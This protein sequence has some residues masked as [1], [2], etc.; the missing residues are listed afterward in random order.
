M[1]CG[2]CKE[3]NLSMSELLALVDEL[4]ERKKADD[5]IYSCLRLKRDKIEKENY[6]KKEE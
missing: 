5:F 2:N 1:L 4:L 6:S 3:R